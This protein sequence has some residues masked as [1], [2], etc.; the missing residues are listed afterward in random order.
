MPPMT[1]H[2]QDRSLDGLPIGLPERARVGRA[3]PVS[4]LALRSLETARV[5]RA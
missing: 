5:F 4:L 1:A 3:R 2:P